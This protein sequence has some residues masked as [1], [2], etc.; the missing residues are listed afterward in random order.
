MLNDFSKMF[1]ANEMTKAWQQSMDIK[2]VVEASKQNTDA[3]KQ[4]SS[5]MADAMNSCFGRQVQMMQ[6][7]MQESVEA[8]QKLT[9]SQG[10]EDYMSKQNQ[11]A[12]KVATKDKDNGQELAKIMQDGQTKAMNLM[13]KQ[14][15]NNVQSV[16][17]QNKT[18][19]CAA[20]SK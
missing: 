12:Q 3:L 9:T 6:N 2:G 15:T 11:M 7:A 8:V 13:A 4:A 19:A 16:Q 1:N 18:A 14:A 5:I 17:K 10:I 20:T